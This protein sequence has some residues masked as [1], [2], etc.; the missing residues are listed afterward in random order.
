MRARSAPSKEFD[1]NA[2][3]TQS[4][5]P[6][7]TKSRAVRKS[8][9]I[10]LGALALACSG[11][12]AQAQGHGFH[13]GG[14]H[15]GGYHGGGYY[16][17]G[18]WGWG[19]WL[20]LGLGLGLAAPL[21]YDQPDVVYVNPPLYY[22][23]ATAYAQAPAYATPAPVAPAPATSPEPIFYPRNGQAAA[24]VEADRQACNRWATTQPRA[25]SDGS[26]FQRATLA[27]M[28]GRGY[29]AR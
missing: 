14:W 19:P 22:P 25:M 21:Y 23:P 7:R 9:A 26:V 4:N 20:G 6:A 13:G 24:Q 18:G 12:A 29:T 2:V 5:T 3:I 28:D 8:L 10:A 15:G 17:G 1:M 11:G 16:R 27:C